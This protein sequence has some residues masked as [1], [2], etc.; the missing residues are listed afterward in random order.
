MKQYA[1][2]ASI[3]LKLFETEAEDPY[4]VRGL[5][6]AHAGMGKL[7]EAEARLAAYL[8][9]HPDSSAALYGKGLILMIQQEPQQ[10]ESWLKRALEKDARNSPA[11]NTLAVLYFD[12]KDYE[13]AV[14]HLHQAAD[15]TPGDLL[16]YRN[17]WRTYQAM[18]QTETFLEEFEAAKRAGAREKMLGYGRAYAGVVRQEAFG[19]YQ[20]GDRK[21]AIEKMKH[22]LRI[23]REIDHPPGI[24]SALFSLGLLSEEEKKPEKARKYYREILEISPDHIQARERLENLEKGG[25]NQ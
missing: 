4:V 1:P 5:I 22:L 3:F 25:Q 17:L 14:Q 24:V 18:G 6:K 9:Q 16:I 8:E 12:R 23:Y 21:Q 15:L 2:A 10:A 13:N 11:H 7:T 20:R 19:A